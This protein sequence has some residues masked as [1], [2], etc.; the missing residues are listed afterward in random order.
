MD[1][2]TY[3][4]SPRHLT[5]REIKSRSLKRKR[6]DSNKIQINCSPRSVSK[7][8]D[9]NRLEI[10]NSPKAINKRIASSKLQIASSPKAI[11]RRTLNASKSKPVLMT[12][13]TSPHSH[14]TSKFQSP[15]TW[16]PNKNQRSLR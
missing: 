14:R 15:K 13:T 8:V 6:I 11:Y 5:V 3:I 2:L 9:S 12:A 4:A 1:K 16:T 10:T 7:R